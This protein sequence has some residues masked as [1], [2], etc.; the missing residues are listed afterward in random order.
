MAGKIGDVSS[1]LLKGA[2]YKQYLGT[3][4][5]SPGY[6]FKV[7]SKPILTATRN[8]SLIKGSGFLGHSIG[9]VTVGI[10]L[11]DEGHFG[12]K[13]KIATAKAITS[14][15][16]ALAGG[17]GGAYIGGLTGGWIADKIYD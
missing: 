11:A 1:G 2:Q 17:A 4:K 9:F 16:G 12:N 7:Y 6:G 10:T 13:T 8:S 15:V 5:P 3:I 14:A